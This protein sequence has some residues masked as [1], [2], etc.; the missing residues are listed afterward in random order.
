MLTAIKRAHRVLLKAESACLV[1]LLLSMIGL[2]VTQIVLRNF[3]GFGVIWVESALRIIVFWTALFGAMRAA[4]NN[5]HIAIDAL[6]NW[7]PEAYAHAI[8]RIAFCFTAAVC[9]VLA[10]YG[11]QF[12]GLAYET[13]ETAFA[14]VPGWVCQA[15][16]PFV[17]FVM[18]CRYFRH[19]VSGLFG[20]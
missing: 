19:A 15:I 18:A 3:F 2:A 17:F 20:K 5:K 8:Q 9:L 7:S 1:L 6:V 13:G 14:V 11:Y 12:V 10:F 16:I 4:R